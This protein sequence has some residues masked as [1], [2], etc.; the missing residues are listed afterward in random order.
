MKKYKIKTTR[1]RIGGIDEIIK[2]SPDSDLIIR[3]E[4]HCP[5]PV[6][7]FISKDEIDHLLE[8]GWIE[9]I[10]EDHERIH[11]G[12]IRWNMNNMLEIELKGA[13]ENSE[14]NIRKIQHAIN[15]ELYDIDE[16]ESAFYKWD[17]GNDK[18]TDW[19]IFRDILK[20]K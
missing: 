6:R 11:I 4:D 7:P 13:T 2:E 3:E 15:G 17:L 10:K 18:D 20:D 19:K 1:L 9:E 14:I 16:I 8:M 12:K 5:S